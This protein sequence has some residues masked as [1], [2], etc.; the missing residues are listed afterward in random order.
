MNYFHPKM[1]IFKCSSLCISQMFKATL[2]EPGFRKRSLGF[3]E[4]SWSKCISTFKYREKLSLK[5][6]GQMLDFFSQCKLTYVYY[7]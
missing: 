6:L 5:R 4:K 2:Y 1:L 3:R 7:M